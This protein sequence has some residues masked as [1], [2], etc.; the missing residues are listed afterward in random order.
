MRYREHRWLNLMTLL[1]RLLRAELFFTS[2][3]S[4][5]SDIRLVA[6]SAERYFEAKKL[7]DRQVIPRVVRSESRRLCRMMNF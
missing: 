5:D 1:P 7:Q 3:I 6:Q 2:P 4:N